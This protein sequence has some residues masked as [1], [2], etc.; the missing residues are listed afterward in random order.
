[1]GLFD[2]FKKR[3]KDYKEVAADNT[4]LSERDMLIN[5]IGSD[6]IQYICD[7][8]MIKKDNLSIDFLT[9]LASSEEIINFLTQNFL[10]SESVQKMNNN[11]FSLNDALNNFQY[12]ILRFPVL[13]KDDEKNKILLLNKEIK[14]SQGN[15]VSVQ[16]DDFNLNNLSL[17]EEYDTAIQSYFSNVTIK[18]DSKK[19]LSVK[20]ND[21]YSIS[22]INML[23]PSNNIILMIFLIV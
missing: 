14:V 17:N 2:G 1:M 23:F 8:Y 4:K 20:L 13:F 22:D 5:K 9:K 21:I 7:M 16:M 15:Y 11:N 10:T 18:K 3:K 19:I 12:D 6:K